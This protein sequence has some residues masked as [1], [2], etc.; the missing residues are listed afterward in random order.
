[1]VLKQKDVHSLNDERKIK[2]KTTTTKV[3]VWFQLGFREFIPCVKGQAEKASLGGR[4][5]MKI[6]FQPGYYTQ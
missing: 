1:M 4:N 5:R 2:K 3:L 6:T